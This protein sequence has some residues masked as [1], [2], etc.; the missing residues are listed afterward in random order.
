MGGGTGP[1]KEA[2]GILLGHTGLSS[3]AKVGRSKFSE[4]GREESLRQG[5]LGKFPGGRVPQYIRSQQKPVISSLFGVLTP[6]LTGLR[7]SQPIALQHPARSRTP[8]MPYPLQRPTHPVC[9]SL[10]VPT[11]NIM[12][13]DSFV[14]K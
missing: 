7:A 9:T 4:E 6:C 2:R 13:L 11:E 3:D 14:T 8:G 1:V 12:G 10:L 5:S